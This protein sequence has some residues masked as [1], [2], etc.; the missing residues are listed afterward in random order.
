PAPAKLPV[1]RRPAPA[2]LAHLLVLAAIMLIGFAL[3]VHAL[4]GR[5]LWGDEAASLDIIMDGWRAVFEPARETHPPLHR[6]LYKP[7]V[8]WVGQKPLFAL[9]YAPMLA[10]VLVVPLAY[11]LARRLFG[12]GPGQSAARLAALLAA[13]GPLYVYY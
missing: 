10:G 1:M 3:R 5:D 12:R 9:R 4:D 2:R 6:A 13:V 8:A 11:D 7:W